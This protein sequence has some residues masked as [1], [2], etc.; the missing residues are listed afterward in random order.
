[1]L[2]LASFVERRGEENGEKVANEYNIA[3]AALPIPLERIDSTSARR[4]SIRSEEEE[5]A[6]LL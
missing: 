2:V 6:K 4:I 1:M 3:L 5:Q